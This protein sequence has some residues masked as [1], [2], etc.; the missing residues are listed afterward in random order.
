MQQ[1]ILTL[2]AN[3][4]LEKQLGFPELQVGYFNQTLIGNVPV[5][6]G[7]GPFT[8]KDRF[9]GATFGISVPLLSRT[10]Q[11]QRKWFKLESEKVKE[12]LD[13]S[14]YAWKTRYQSLLM[15][16]TNAKSTFDALNQ[17]AEMLKKNM[18]G[19]VIE[20]LNNGEIDQLDAI[21][22][23]LNIYKINL[24]ELEMMHQLNVLSLEFNYLSF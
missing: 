23:Q 20:Q 14:V 13:Q 11:Q 24:S 21:K 9:Q 6:M 8:S 12:E 3:Q 7:V 5:N 4:R 19:V 2:D 22:L 17:T 15:Q 1:A 18:K 16:Y 10:N